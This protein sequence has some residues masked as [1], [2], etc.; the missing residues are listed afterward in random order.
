VLLPTVL[1]LVLLR[2][3]LL[4]LLLLLLSAGM[5]L[6][7]STAPTCQTPTGLICSTIGSG[8]A[9]LLNRFAI[10]AKPSTSHIQLLTLTKSHLYVA[11]GDMEHAAFTS[12]F[13]GSLSQRHWLQQPQI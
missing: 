13:S 2:L 8:V 3:L 7:C 11:Y 4:L 10:L 6:S 1:L 9:K 5:A 12:T